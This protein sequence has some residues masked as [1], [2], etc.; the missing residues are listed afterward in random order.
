MIIFSFSFEPQAA[1]IDLNSPIQ[2]QE[3]KHPDYCPCQISNS[4]GPLERVDAA[5]VSQVDLELRISSSRLNQNSSSPKN[6][7]LGA[8]RVT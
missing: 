8:I 5:E 3:M 6:L 2:E 7:C 1:T 4:S